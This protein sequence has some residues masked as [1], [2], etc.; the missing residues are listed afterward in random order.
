M[1]KYTFT[2][3]IQKV[4]SSHHYVHLDSKIVDEFEKKEKTR[5]LCVLD[6]IVSYSCQ[7]KKQGDTHLIMI[8]ASNLKKLK[9]HVGDEV[10]FEICQ[11]PNPL[12]VDVPEVLE[13]FL[14]QD[15]EAKAIY[16]TFTD[17][18]KRTL[19]FQ[20]IRVKNIDKQIQRITDFLTQEKIK[21]LQK[22]SS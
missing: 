15:P 1:K 3:R 16:D 12:G 13:V 21:Q 8:S 9:K 10:A 22:R 6:D 4:A 18:K 11:H 14:E 19:I 2:Q 20:I 5:L 7:I 17:G